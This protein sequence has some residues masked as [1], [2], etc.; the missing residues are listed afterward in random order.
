MLGTS[1]AY[2][3][4]GGGFMEALFDK[5]YKMLSSMLDYRSARQKVIS[6]NVANIDTPDFKPKDL[7]FPEA[8][9]SAL[10]SSSVDLSRTHPQHIPVGKPDSAKFTTIE[11]GE[12]TSL[13]ME[14]MNV[15]E[16]NLNYNL[17]VELLARKFKGIQNVLKE[18]R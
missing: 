8:L 18:T 7:K 12:K 4:N 9:K 5:T 1:F 13:D 2:E 15:A 14:M 10:D 17:T 3:F 6:S 11:T 16:N